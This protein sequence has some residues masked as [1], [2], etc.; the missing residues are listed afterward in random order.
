MNWLFHGQYADGLIHKV[1]ITSTGLVHP[2]KKQCGLHLKIST[3]LETLS[4]LCLHSHGGA[5]ANT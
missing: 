1:G 5:Q 2:D 3:S 4:Y